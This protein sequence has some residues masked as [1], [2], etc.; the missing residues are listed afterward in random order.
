[1][2]W[3]SIWILYIYSMSWYRGPVRDHLYLYK[4][5]A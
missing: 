5:L 3:A 2:I 4:A 1:V